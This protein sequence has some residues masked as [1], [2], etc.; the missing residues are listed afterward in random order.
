MSE[1]PTGGVR[2]RRRST[3]ARRLPGPV[4][5]TRRWLPPVVVTLVTLVAFL[6][7][8]GNGFASWDDA[9]NFLDNPHYRGLGPAQLRWMFTTFHVGHYMPLTW[10]TL[11]LDYSLWGLHP[12]GYH[13]TSLLLHTATALAFYFLA[14][15]LLQV[16]LPPATTPL[17]LPWAAALAALVF[18]VP[19]L[20]VESGAWANERGDV[21]SGLFYVLARRCYAKTATTSPSG[22]A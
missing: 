6:P 18:A 7:T 11:G 4:R 10:L 3:G 17:A 20:R 2:A 1:C 8:L 21:L 16:A 5:M 12:A 9:L 22:P 19:P 13:F 15:R 14:L